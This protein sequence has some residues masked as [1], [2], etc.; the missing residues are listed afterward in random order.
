MSREEMQSYQM[1]RLRR[2]YQLKKEDWFTGPNASV[3]WHLVIL[4][5]M[6]GGLHSAVF[7]FCLENL[8]TEEQVKK[9]VPMAKA[10]RIMGSYS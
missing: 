9:W 3:M 8:A 4:G 7:L 1:M 10:Y 2:A 5:K 6:I